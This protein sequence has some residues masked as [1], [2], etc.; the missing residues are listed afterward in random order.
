MKRFSAV[1]K[2]GDKKCADTDK[3]WNLRERKAENGGG[4]QD[5]WPRG[6]EK[7]EILRI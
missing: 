6:G 3:K 7:N 5:E 4:R 1:K 2:P